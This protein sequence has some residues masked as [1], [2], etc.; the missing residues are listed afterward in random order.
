MSSQ[1]TWRYDWCGRMGGIPVELKLDVLFS[2][3][4]CCSKI[5]CYIVTFINWPVIFNICN[6]YIINIY[7][8][9]TDSR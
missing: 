1:A 4:I 5:S 8:F 6:K 3:F 7:S 9:N 2:A